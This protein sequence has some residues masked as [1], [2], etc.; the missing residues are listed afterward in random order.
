MFSVTE[1]INVTKFKIIFEIFYIKLAFNR[2]NFKLNNLL[3][4]AIIIMSN[5]EKIIL[6]I[7]EQNNRA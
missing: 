1:W 6:T 7:I 3:K 5:P 4:N 2:F